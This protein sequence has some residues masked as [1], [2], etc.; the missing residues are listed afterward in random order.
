[1]FGDPYTKRTCLWLKNLPKLVPTNIVDKGEI[2]VHGGKRIPKWYSNHKKQ[3]DRTFKG[4][5]KAMA[6]QWGG[7]G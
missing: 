3:R 5:A 6:E 1:M 2:I 7:D 4:I